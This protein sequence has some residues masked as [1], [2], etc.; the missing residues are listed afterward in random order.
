M[1]KG[2]GGE[3]CDSKRDV[4]MGIF[5]LL[6]FQREPFNHFIVF[7]DAVVL[8]ILLPG[9]YLFQKVESIIGKI[10]FL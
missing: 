5:S 2:K 3:K 9:F 1:R 4:V 8:D 7:H 6:P 10:G